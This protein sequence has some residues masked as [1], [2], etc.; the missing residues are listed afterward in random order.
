M[1]D[2]LKLEILELKMT[3]KLCKELH[4]KHVNSLTQKYKLLNNRNENMKKEKK[5]LIRE[6]LKLR[7][8][9]NE[10][11]QQNHS[12]K[13]LEME[14]YDSDKFI[15]EISELLTHTNSS[16]EAFLDTINNFSVQKLYDNN[17]SNE[18]SKTLEKSNELLDE[19]IEQIDDIYEKN[20]QKLEDEDNDIK[21][22]IFHNCALMLQLLR[23][24]IQITQKFNNQCLKKMNNTSCINSNDNGDKN[25]IIHNN[26]KITENRNNEIDD[27]DNNNNSNNNN[28]NGD[29]DDS[30]DNSNDSN[31]ININNH[32]QNNSL[33][34]YLFSLNPLKHR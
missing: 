1:I 2:N 26:S 19:L 28:D 32:Q 20:E 33:I 10:N 23:K 4:E 6:V 17:V 5:V 13:E 7:E 29:D 12:M 15:D 34:N 11:T 3:H 25:N 27:D 9:I 8:K 24:Y 30:D 21:K 16:Y 31:D 22:Q 14:L 18:Q